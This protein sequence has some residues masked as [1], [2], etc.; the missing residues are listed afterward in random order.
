MVAAS[1]VSNFGQFNAAMA[2]QSRVIWA[3][4][5]AEGNSEICAFSND[6]GTSQKLPGF[7]AIAW[8]RHTG[9]TYFIL[10]LL[11]RN[12]SSYCSSFI[13]WRNVLCSYS[14][15]VPYLGK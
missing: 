8:Q 3:M 12:D 2:P 4:A 13:L 15:S 14:S 9:F 1:A 11:F 5:Q 7:L 10:S 6:L